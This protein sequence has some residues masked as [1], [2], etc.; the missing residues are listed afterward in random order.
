MKDEAL[1]QSTVAKDSVHD[2][3]QLAKGAEDVD[4]LL[5]LR[6]PEKTVITPSYGNYTV[7]KQYA[8]FLNFATVNL[9]ILL[10]LH[11]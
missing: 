7:I 10:V 4:H 3:T 6:V 5:M 1:H 11:L 9:V 2:I 8:Y